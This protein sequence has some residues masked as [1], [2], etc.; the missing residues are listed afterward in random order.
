[1]YFKETVCL[2]SGGPQCKDDT[3]GRIQGG[4]QDLRTP[5]RFKNSFSIALKGKENQVENR[6][7]NKNFAFGA[8]LSS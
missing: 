6:K 2:I 3:Q 4:R 5:L 8:S 1:M 7:V